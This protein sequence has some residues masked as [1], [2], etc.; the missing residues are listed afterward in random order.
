M[1]FL[2]YPLRIAHISD[3]HFSKISLSPKM[4]FSKRWFGN[5]N[6]IFFRRNLYNPKNAFLLPEFLSNER[7]SHIV[8]TGDMTTTSLEKEYMLAKELID[9]LQSANMT[10][11]LIPGNHDHYTKQTCND[12]IFYQY[13]PKQF[14]NFLPEWN[15]EDHRITVE[16]LVDN[17]YLIGLDTTKAATLLDSTGVFSEELERSLERVLQELPKDSRVIVANHFPLFTQ[18]HNRR[19]MRRATALQ[20]LIKR[21]PSIIC[22]LHGHTHRRCLADLRKSDYPIIMDSGS[23]SHQKHGSFHI[24]EL[25]PDILQIY[26]YGINQQN[27]SFILHSHEQFRL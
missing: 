2:A 1:Y 5:L 6:L 26:I 18:E 3:L 14:S 20:Q 27:G 25:H 8:I 4:F 7:V 11:Y 21:F 9:E 24:L 22:Y 17:F 15:L 19:I 13:F 10:T 23:F 12:R 16:H